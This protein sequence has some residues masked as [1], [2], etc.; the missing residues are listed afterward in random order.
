[1]EAEKNFF[2]ALEFAHLKGFFQTKSRFYGENEKSRNFDNIPAS[3]YDIT[4][5]NVQWSDFDFFCKLPKIL[6]FFHNKKE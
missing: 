6:F 4:V 5:A 3:R 1:M 2:S